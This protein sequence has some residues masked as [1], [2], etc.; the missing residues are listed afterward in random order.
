LVTTTAAC[1]V[2]LSGS[3]SAQTWELDVGRVRIDHDPSPYL[4][5]SGEQIPTGIG[6]AARYVW[7]SGVFFGVA[8]SRGSDVGA[9]AICGGFIF[10]PV[11]QCIPESIRYS[12]GH[13]ALIAGWRFRLEHRSGLW[14]GIRPT[15]ELGST[16]TREVG[17]ATGRAFYESRLTVGLGAGL[18]AG[19]QLPW[20]RIGIMISAGMAQLR[21]VHVDR[22]LDCRQELY[23]PMPLSRIGVGLTW[24]MP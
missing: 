8:S 2:G 3:V 19:Y 7:R 6:L 24:E 4:T 20:R 21:P 22:C 15:A 9:G 12:G 13:M 16:W 17:R 10:D 5:T 18:E 14:V 1:V 11:D 23:E